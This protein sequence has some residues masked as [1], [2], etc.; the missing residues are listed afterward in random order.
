MTVCNF[1]HKIS[2][3]IFAIVG[4]KVNFFIGEVQNQ[5]KHIVRLCIIVI[6]IDVSANYDCVQFS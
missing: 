5:I 4:S 3:T 1:A 6:S 2:E